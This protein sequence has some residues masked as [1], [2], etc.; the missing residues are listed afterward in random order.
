MHVSSTSGPYLYNC[1]GRE[2]EKRK[3]TV[4]K[5]ARAR[6]LFESHRVQIGMRRFVEDYVTEQY[7][8]HHPRFET[9]ENVQAVVPVVPDQTL[10][11]AD[12]REPA[13]EF[14]YGF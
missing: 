9:V 7:Q 6:Y 8:H 14:R 10:A 4:K 13:D 5:S 12:G 2:R 1:N 3:R 11:V